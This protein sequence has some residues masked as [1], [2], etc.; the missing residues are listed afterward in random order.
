MTMDRWMGKV[1]CAYDDK[2]TLL[3]NMWIYLAALTAT[4]L[5]SLWMSVD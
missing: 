3:R 1:H 5:L 4:I 2:D